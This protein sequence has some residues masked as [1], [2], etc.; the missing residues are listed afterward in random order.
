[1][2]TAAEELPAGLFRAGAY[3]PTVAQNLLRSLAIQPHE[4]ANAALDKALENALIRRG[5]ALAAQESILDDLENWLQGSER[6]FE[7]QH[8]RLVHRTFQSL[9]LPISWPITKLLMQR[10]YG[11]GDYGGARAAATQALRDAGKE[12]PDELTVRCLDILGHVSSAEGDFPS[13]ARQWAAGAEAARRAKLDYDEWDLRVGLIWSLQTMGQFVDALEEIDASESIA[14]R[15]EDCDA[16]SKTLIDEGNTMLHMGR[17]R[18]AGRAFRGGLAAARVSNNR[19]RQSDALGN[20]GSV[21]DALGDPVAAEQ[22]HRQALEISLTLK[23]KQSAQFDCNNLAQ[24]LWKQGRSQEA[25]EYEEQAVAFARQRNDESHLERYIA[26]ARRMAEALGAS[27]NDATEAP[28]EKHKPPE[29]QPIADVSEPS[30]SEI[31]ER[32][33]RAFLNE[34]KPDEANA[35]MEDHLARYPS[36]ARARALYAVLQLVAGNLEKALAEVEKAVAAAPHDVDVHLRLADVYTRL[37]RLPELLARYENQIAEQP[38]QPALRAGLALVYNRLGRSDQAAQQALEGVRMAPSD[39]LLIRVLAEAQFNISMSRLRTD[40]DAAW[41]AFQECAT[42]LV[43][44]VAQPVSPQRKSEWTNFMA[45]C[46]E[47]FAMTSFESNP[48]LMGGME[49]NE[50]YLLARAVRSY[51]QAQEYDAGRVTTDAQNRI[52]D[53]ML[54]FGQPQQMA[55]AA[56]DLRNEGDLSGT[57]LVLT[58]SLQKQPDQAAAYCEL[59]WTMDAMGDRE[60][61]RKYIQRALEFEP[62]NPECREAERLL[63]MPPEKKPNLGEKIL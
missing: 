46:L 30:D 31:V 6:Q 63:A 48:P 14:V 32:Q 47:R 37:D 12:P 35:F 53:I 1:M 28:P 23:N 60:G 49:S 18:E 40:W 3:G 56:R 39:A 20:I 22:F 45:Q 59:A 27:R 43:R 26:S 51:R 13:A 36:D 57:I 21:M 15:M 10:A 44:L 8:V 16:I 33:V 29:E 5:F 4:K 38:F 17:Y 24:V 55:R 19:P 62:D 9:N 11:A 7:Y 42:T 58:L 54:A 2:I 52:G 41:T 25:L 61:A 50:L 34:Q